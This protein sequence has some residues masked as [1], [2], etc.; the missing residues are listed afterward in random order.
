MEQE[1]KPGGIERLY[2]ACFRPSR[3]K[4]LLSV[5]TA[6]HV[7]YA[8]CIIFFL[9]FIETMLP[10]AAWDFSVGGLN[11][12]INERF[13]A[14]TVENGV[15]KI[16]SPVE[17]NINGVIRFKADSGVEKFRK[18]DLD[19]EYQEEFL[20]SSSNVLIKLADRVVDIP[21]EEV[22]KTRLDNQ[23]MVNAIP[24][25]RILL[26]IYFLS[27]YVIKGA[28]YMIAAVFFAFLCRAAIRAPDGRFVTLKGTIVIAIYAKT[29]FSLVHSV[30]ICMGSPVGETL[31]LIIG[32]FGTIA[33]IDRAEAAV[34][35]VSFKN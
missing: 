5:K 11:R 17:F 9:V 16:E 3:Y 13:P 14:F 21:M 7:V 29:L 6:R 28:E 12:L 23:S 20:F 33:F 25:L 31:M 19:E 27:S 4:E 10:F 30:N 35:N 22:S 2:I 15:M 24:F 18:K 1:K 26:G 8:C 34:L 32:T